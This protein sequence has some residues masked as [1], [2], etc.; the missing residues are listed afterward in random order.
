M[1][2]RSEIA[3]KETFKI[4]LQIKLRGVDEDEERC[5]KA[6]GEGRSRNANDGALQLFY[7]TGR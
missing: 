6:C 7:I 4:E 1:E 5:L 2:T 3:E